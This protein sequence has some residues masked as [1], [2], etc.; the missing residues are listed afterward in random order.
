MSDDA[1]AWLDGTETIAD[2][3]HGRAREGA[4]RARCQDCARLE[5]ALRR[6]L[7]LL[8][9]EADREL[10]AEIARGALEG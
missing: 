10:A 6:I 8:D 2:L 4:R 5:A 3:V 1:R 9:G 7:E